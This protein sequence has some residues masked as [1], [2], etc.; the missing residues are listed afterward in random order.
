MAASSEAAYDGLSG[1]AG[2]AGSLIRR[3]MSRSATAGDLFV[4]VA[5]G[6]GPG[7]PA[8]NVAPTVPA[9][10]RGRLIE[11]ALGGNIWRH[12][13]HTL[14]T[15]PSWGAFYFGNPAALG[16]FKADARA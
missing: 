7:D 4:V 8:L 12:P 9:N 16:P 1:V 11:P 2:V 15:V 3:L 10:L 13:P 6:T 14:P 5:E